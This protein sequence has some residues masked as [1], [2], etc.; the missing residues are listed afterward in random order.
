MWEGVE[1]ILYQR[2]GS[3]KADH[4]V[5]GWLADDVEESFDERQEKSIEFEQYDM[6]N[7]KTN[8]DGIAE[9]GHTQ[10]AWFEDPEGNI[11][12]ITE[13]PH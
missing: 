7:L 13:S 12:A 2:E 11:I 4:T 3:T 8:E 6:P 9:I 5:A 10:S 1:L